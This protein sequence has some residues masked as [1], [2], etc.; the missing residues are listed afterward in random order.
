VP[1]VVGMTGGIGSGKSAVAR[2]FAARDVEI[3]DADL[4]AHRLSSRDQ[5]GYAAIVATFDA[6]VLLPSGELDRAE[7]RRRAF[8][9]PAARA[10]LEGAL[11]PLIRREMQQEIAGWHGAYGVAVV[12]LLLERSSVAKWVDRVLVVDC[13]EGEQVH[14]VVVRSGLSPEEVR[15]IMATQLDRHT[16]LR[17]ADDVLDNSGPPEAIAPQVAWLDRRYTELAA[18][19]LRAM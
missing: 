9:D 2:A 17:G 14:R 5:P 10:R 11:H 8:A 7:L 16:R 15:A 3:T 4:I 12:P 1:Y 18:E 19:R 6:A 13:P